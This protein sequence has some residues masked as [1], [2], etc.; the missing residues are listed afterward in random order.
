ML[1]IFSRLCQD[2]YAAIAIQYGLIASLIY[3]TIGTV[4]AAIAR[5]GTD[6]SAPR[7]PGANRS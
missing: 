3:A 5:L 4:G 7:R 6:P 1:P 2:E